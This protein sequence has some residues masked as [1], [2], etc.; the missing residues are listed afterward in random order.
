MRTC[1]ATRIR[2]VHL[3]YHQRSCERFLAHTAQNMC[4]RLIILMKESWGSEHL[5][6]CL[7]I[8]I[9]HSTKCLHR[10][11]RKEKEVKEVQIGKEANPTTLFSDSTTFHFT[12]VRTA[13]M[14]ELENSLKFQGTEPV[15]KRHF[16]IPKMNSLKEKSKQNQRNSRS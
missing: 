1:L 16:H 9:Q 5:S 10:L 15:S 6:V 11:L 7:S 8:L 13:K 12:K 14:L 3:L 4:H 2:Y